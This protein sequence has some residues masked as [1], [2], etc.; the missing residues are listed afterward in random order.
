MP[1]QKYNDEAKQWLTAKLLHRKVTLVLHRK[2]QYQRLVCTVYRPFFALWKR[3]VSLE[4]LEAGWA[5]VYTSAGAE[6]N[7]EEE[8]YLKAEA[9]AK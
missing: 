7:N 9:L 1:K 4:M 6:Y 3:N 5:A 8:A 2:D